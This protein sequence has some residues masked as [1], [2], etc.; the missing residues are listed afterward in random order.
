[1][2]MASAT[3][4]DGLINVP[5]CP[6]LAPTT[7][8]INQ[9]LASASQTAAAA[10]TTI[11][12]SAQSTPRLSRAPVAAAPIVPAA[13]PSVLK[14][15]GS[16]MD[17]I[18]RVLDSKKNNWPLWSESMLNLFEINEVTE[19]VEGKVVCPDPA[20]DPL[21]ERN[22]RHNDAYAKI[23]INKNLSEEERSYTQKCETS[24]KMWINLKTIYEPS[25]ALDLT[26][27]LATLFQMRAIEGSNIPEHLNSLKIQWDRLSFELFYDQLLGDVFFKRIIAQSL[28]R[29]WDAFTNP[30]VSG[31]IDEEADK[32]RFNLKRVTSQLLIGKIKR[33]Y[34]LNEFHSHHAFA[35]RQQY[36][37]L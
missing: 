37:I 6:I 13:V 4:S 29:S 25:D 27:E 2:D 11:Q 7:Q 31:P 10:Q 36:H 19:Y 28:P 24:H 33:Q 35:L 5:D 22:W 8:P 1:M 9:P 26:D 18:E 34:H 12:S 16:R 17:K 3:S 30:Y 15:S 32:D 23:L 21:G 20:L 14:I